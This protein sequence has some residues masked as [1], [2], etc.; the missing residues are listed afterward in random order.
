M[1]ND[2]QVRLLNE[3]LLFV[4]NTMY[5]LNRKIYSD[6]IE[7]LDQYKVTKDCDLNDVAIPLFNEL[8][9]ISRDRSWR[10]GQCDALLDILDSALVLADLSD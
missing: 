10:K 2:T 4:R 5:G 6:A 7:L 1:M 9:A 8:D 3:S